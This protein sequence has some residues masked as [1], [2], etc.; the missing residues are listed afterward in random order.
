MDETSL[1]LALRAFFES[2]RLNL[3][4]ELF[5]L[6]AFKITDANA[7]R[8]TDFLFLKSSS[9]ETM[10]RSSIPVGLQFEP[11]LDIGT[12]PLLP[13]FLL[14]PFFKKSLSYFL[15]FLISFYSLSYFLYFWHLLCSILKLPFQAFLL[16]LLNFN[17]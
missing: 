11:T 7:L 10:R 17:F 14:P 2:G 6:A 1:R 8:A 9:V 5:R 3:A 16:L 4:V 13:L 12:S 15:F